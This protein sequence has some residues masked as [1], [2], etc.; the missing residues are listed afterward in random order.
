M[1]QTTKGLSAFI[2]KQKKPKKTAGTTD[3]QPEKHAAGTK[4]VQVEKEKEG[5]KNTPVAKEDSSDEEVDEMDVAAQKLNYGNIKE[6]KDI[7]GNKGDKD[8]QGFGFEE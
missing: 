8:K 2:K 3:E 5:Q 4:D 7:S 6:K 1:S